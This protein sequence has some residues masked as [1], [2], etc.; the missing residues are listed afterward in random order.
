MASFFT[1]LLLI[2]CLVLAFSGITIVL[3]NMF[4]FVWGGSPFIASPL[5]ILR[6]MIDLA[7]LKKTDRVYDLGCGDGRILIEASR[8]YGV[9]ATGLEYSPFIFWLARLKKQLYRADIRIVRADFYKFDFSD[10]DV[11]FCYLLPE[12]MQK[13]EQKFRRLK[14]GSRIVS[15]QFEIPGW[16]ASREVTINYRGKVYT[17]MQYQV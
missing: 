13:L 5:R 1:K 6:A 11:V 14:K 2:S 10:A 8:K 9:R 4:S 15:H 12:Q 17:L 16:R 7:D 3:I